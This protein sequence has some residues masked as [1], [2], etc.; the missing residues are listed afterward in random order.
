MT[1]YFS[2]YAHVNCVVCGKRELRLQTGPRIVRYCSSACRQKAYRKRK[3]LRND[4]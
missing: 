3:G 1:Y 2:D 4:Y